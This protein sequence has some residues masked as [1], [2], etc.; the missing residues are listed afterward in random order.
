[1]RKKRDLESDSDSSQEQDHAFT[2]QINNLSNLQFDKFDQVMDPA[3]LFEFS[4]S[5]NLTLSVNTEDK[6]GGSHKF[7]KSL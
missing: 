6:N 5:P 2:K 3:K 7:F 4:K 1:M